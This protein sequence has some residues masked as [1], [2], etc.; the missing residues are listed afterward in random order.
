MQADTGYLELQKLNDNIA[1]I[2]TDYE[3]LFNADPEIDEVFSKLQNLV[4]NALEGDAPSLNA[5]NNGEAFEDVSSRLDYK[6]GVENNNLEDF[7][8]IQDGINKGL[9]II[10]LKKELLS[11]RLE[12]SKK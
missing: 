2:T 8:M 6:L 12:Y 10:E 7:S 4:T 1:M 3:K 5:I 11:L 9:D